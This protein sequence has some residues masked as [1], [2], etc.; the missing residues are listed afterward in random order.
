VKGDS[1]IVVDASGTRRS[2]KDTANARER[3]SFTPS[4]ELAMRI[5]G[6]VKRVGSLVSGGKSGPTTAQC[7]SGPHDP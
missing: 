1:S 6:R 2:V 3:I 5:L 7:L 4:K